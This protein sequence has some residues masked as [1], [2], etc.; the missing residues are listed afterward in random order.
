M[1]GKCQNKVEWK[2][3]RGKVKWRKKWKIEKGKKRRKYKE[4]KKWKIKKLK[5]KE[6]KDREVED[7]K[8]G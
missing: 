1:K 4:R 5:I 3:G 2:K 6:E 8:R 7:K